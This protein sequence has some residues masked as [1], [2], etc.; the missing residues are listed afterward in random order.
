MQEDNSL[1]IAAQLIDRAKKGEQ[2]TFE[3][4]R[5]LEEYFA[6]RAIKKTVKKVVK[7]F[8]NSKNI[9]YN[10]YIKSVEEDTNN[11]NVILS[12]S[13]LEQVI[14]FYTTEIEIV[15]D[16]IDEYSVYV[17]SGHI[18]DTIVGNYR[19]EEDLVDFRKVVWYRGEE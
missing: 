9:L 18:F 12:I 8:T 4:I 5:S 16:M 3:F 19:K 7:S 11:I 6:A 15:S 17:H 1:Q 10:A 13:E 14:T 2:S